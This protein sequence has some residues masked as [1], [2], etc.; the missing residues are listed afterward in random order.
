MA[1]TAPALLVTGLPRSGTSWV[2][3]M[4]EASR[5][6]VY[7]NEPLNPRHPPGRSPGVLDGEVT[8]RFQ[9]ICADNEQ[10]WL[11][12]FQRTLA[13]RY[14][15]GRELRRNR[16]P[17]DLARLAKYATSFTTGRWRGR[18]A[19]L[20]DPYALLAVPWLAERFG[21]RAVVLVRD[22][23]ALVGSYRK[24]NWHIHLDEL[25]DQP[26]LVR[27]LIGDSVAELREAAAGADEIHQT[28]LL[29]RVMYEVVD[30][31]HRHVPGVTV[32]RYEDLAQRPEEEFASLYDHC[33]LDFDARAR[34]RVVEATTGSGSDRGAMRWTVRFGLSRTAFRPMDSKQA[35]DAAQRRLSTED[36]ERVRKITGQ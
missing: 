4:L 1:G 14:G 28:A 26:L 15:V 32:R 18:R 3:K 6:V 22:P 17:Y 9:Y 35:V 27:D 7:V 34:A 10:A 5:Q 36:A 30:R 20:D 12:A 21:V 19:M 16:G 11:P 8:H 29:W 2:G 23:V 33:G 24:L 31:V 13:L 25:L